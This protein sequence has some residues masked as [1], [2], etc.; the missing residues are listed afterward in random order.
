MSHK[1]ENTRKPDS[2]DLSFANSASICPASLER[3]EERREGVQHPRAGRAPGPRVP[4]TEVTQ[5]PRASLRHL[6]E[7][8]EGRGA[9][10]PSETRGGGRSSGA[11]RPLPGP[12]GTE[13]T[14]GAGLCGPHW[15]SAVP[16]LIKC[17]FWPKEAWRSRG[18]GRVG[19]ACGHR[20]NQSLS[21][22][23]TKPAAQREVNS[24]RLN[25]GLKR[26][27]LQARPVVN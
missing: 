14:W 22:A 23:S 25:G 8:G 9:A 18:V 16:E 26:R 13:V 11:A 24:G 17:L 4:Q 12:R 5:A 21:C 6:G 1:G 2:Y 20:N 19:A 7:P 3:G 10:A 27:H 15:R